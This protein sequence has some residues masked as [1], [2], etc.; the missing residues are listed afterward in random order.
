MG[1]NVL[2]LEDNKA[3][4]NLM[5]Q[6]LQRSGEPFD[7]IK[8]VHNKQTYEEALQNFPADLIL[9]DYR[10]IN[11]TGL[12]AIKLKDSYCEEVPIIIVSATI[13]DEKAVELIKEGAV[14]YLIKNN[15]EKR[16]GQVAIRA[17]RESKEK[18]K[19]LH[20]EYSLKRSEM[21]Y[22]LLFNS[23]MDGILI[24]QPEKKG[25]VLD[26][27][28]A[29]CDLLGYSREELLELRRTDLFQ[30]DGTD[31]Q[32]LLHEREQA[33]E[34][35]FKGELELQH[36]DGSAIPVE[37][38]SRIVELRDGKEQT[39]SIIRDIRERKKA[40]QQMI[41]DQKVQELQ[42]DIAQIV[43]KNMDYTHSLE[44]CIKRIKKF[45][46]WQ[47][48]HIFI[49][50]AQEGSTFQPMNLWKMDNE[51]QFEPFVKGSSVITT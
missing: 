46:G 6:Y 23:S 13:G 50:D 7:K 39:Y 42:K 25:K 31:L 29:L 28:Q 41:W 22:R 30:L 37:I 5:K 11:F 10:L 1:F 27:N 16:L 26:A 4:A 3:D 20:A 38:T 43:N 19:R 40:E 44:A 9:S 51:E 18:E 14:D 17:I 36:K 35:K 15:A 34:K 2:I 32:K 8:L 49:R 33:E 24:G 48:G 47:L 21:R 45:L 12:D